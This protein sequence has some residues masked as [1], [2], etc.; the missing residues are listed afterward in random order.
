MS[1]ETTKP[2]EAGEALAQFIRKNYKPYGYPTLLVSTGG[3]PM[4]CEF[5]LEQAVGSV[6]PLVF[7][8]CPHEVERVGDMR[9]SPLPNLRAI[10]ARAWMEKRR[11]WSHHQD[12]VLVSFEHYR[13]KMEVVVF[14]A[15]CYQAITGESLEEFDVRP[16]EHTVSGGVIGPAEA[17]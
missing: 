15:A 4:E 8:S 2:T 13:N 16:S 1:D 5:G 11:L 7:S 10:A 14:C 12:G 9:S 17:C 3:S 6:I